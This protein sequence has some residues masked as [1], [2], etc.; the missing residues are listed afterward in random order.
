[1]AN[2]SVDIEPQQNL[3]GAV[4][5]PVAAIIEEAHQTF[6]AGTP[7]QINSSDGGVQAWDGNTLTAIAGIAQV[8]A[9]NL[10]STGVGVPSGFTPVLG[11]GS[12]IGSYAANANQPLA[13]I[14]P[15][16]VPFTDGRHYF[17]IA[18][19]STVFAGVIGTSSGTPAAIATANTQVGISYGLTKDPSNNYWYVDVN[20]TGSAVLK[21]VGIDPRMPVGTVGGLVL[22]TFLNA[23]AQIYA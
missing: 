13:N 20:K 11:P 10:S 1:M 22:F 3:G 21:V 8:N 4:S 6:V 15:P 23:A 16:G 7:V 14:L 5:F 19:P 18:D 12:S 17:F 9:Q 2:F